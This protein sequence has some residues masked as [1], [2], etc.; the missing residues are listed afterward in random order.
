MKNKMN[1]LSRQLGLLAA[2]IM[3]FIG[4]FANQLIP[5]KY[6]AFGYKQ[7]GSILFGLLLAVFG[8]FVPNSFT[9]WTDT[10]LKKLDKLDRK[11]FIGAWV[12]VLLSI[13][14]R[15]YLE[16]SDKFL[17][18]WALNSFSSKIEN[19]KDTMPFWYVF[20]PGKVN[21]GGF[22]TP[23]NFLGAIYLPG[24]IG[25]ANCWY[26][27]YVILILSSFFLSYRVT[28]SRIFSYSFAI[29]LC[30]GSHLYHTYY[31]PG[32]FLAPIILVM[33]EFVLYAI[34]QIFTSKNHLKR[35]Y[36]FYLLTLV[37][38]AFT[39]IIWLDLL[40]FLCVA[41]VAGVVYVWNR[42][43]RKKWIKKILL[44][45]VP[46]ILLGII[47]LSFQMFFHPEFKTSV[48]K[49]EEM[50]T[51]YPYLS[52]AADDLVSNY[53]TNLYMTVSSFLPPFMVNSNSYYLLGTDEIIAQQSGYRNNEESN[54]LIENQHTFF[55]RYYAGIWLAIFIFSFVQTGKKVYKEH[56]FHSFTMLL[57][58][59]FSMIGSPTHMMIKSRFYLS[60]PVLTYRVIVPI[61]GLSLFIAYLLK[62][63]RDKSEKALIGI[64]AVWVFYAVICLVRPT[65]LI[66]QYH[67]I[68][69]SVRPT[70]EPIRQLIILI[71]NIFIR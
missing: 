63:W 16:Q 39:N 71:D 55:W 10:L 13:F 47:I 29:L 27:G 65:F 56:D 40:A 14:Q 46:A 19:F 35:R 49:E 26:L 23:F 48:G 57:L 50:V 62:R 36:V 2:L 67:I 21:I 5:G 20:L 66:S 60:V 34:I 6:A 44:V 15:A 30:F 7:L 52:L 42:E 58:I 28:K 54:A 11:Y 37:I 22:Y 4:V 25:V 18:P 53:I 68:Y 12:L 3:I 69:T 8:F 51:R 59:L 43:D 31:T 61:M 1:S 64:I 24:W 33:F 17:Y 32:S 38:S 45:I 41:S 70:P 9:A